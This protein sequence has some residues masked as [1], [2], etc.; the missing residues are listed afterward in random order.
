MK[1][2]I[3]LTIIC[4]TNLDRP[5]LY[6]SFIQLILERNIIMFEE[7]DLIK[8][9]K[10]FDV[11]VVKQIIYHQDDKDEYYYQDNLFKIYEDMFVVYENAPNGFVPWKETLSFASTPSS[12]SLD[13]LIPVF[14]A[15]LDSCFHKVLVNLERGKPAKKKRQRLWKSIKLVM[16]RR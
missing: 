13:G 16:K 6:T 5:F 3:D 2:I 10:L 12:T 14:N 11:H 1:Y 15:Y 7:V 8:A 9:S 4:K